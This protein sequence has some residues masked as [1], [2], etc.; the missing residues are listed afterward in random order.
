MA[1]GRRSKGGRAPE[2]SRR[3][4]RRAEMLEK[5]YRTAMDLFAKR[6]FVATTTEAITEA[7][8]VG[9]G[10]FF[11]YFPT[12]SHVLVVLSEKQ[13]HKLAAARDEA[14]AGAAPVREVFRRL[15]HNIVQE[16][17]RSPALTRS[18]LTAF[19]SQDD[20]RDL[21]GATLAKGRESIGRICAVGQERGEIRRDR[22]PA[23]LA[24]TFQRNVLG[25]LL[26][27]AL[28]SKG[29]L[30]AWLDKTFD[31]FWTVAGGKRE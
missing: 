15:I 20:I 3:E 24:M 22:K 12:K 17:A 31:D 14:E 10:T 19:A 29:D 9:Q 8:D 5:L 7:A 13:L 2:P 16:L 4:R 27:W 18:L 30:H 28:Q 23:D 11:N 25:T 26:I 1:K 6:G 21:M